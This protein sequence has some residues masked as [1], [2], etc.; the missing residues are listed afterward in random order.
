MLHPTW[1]SACWVLYVVVQ[2]KQ[3]QQ[4]KPASAWWTNAIQLL[5]VLLLETAESNIKALNVETIQPIVDSQL[6]DLRHVQPV[7]LGAVKPKFQN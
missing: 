6:N 7:S 4:G 3:Q 1:Q 5:K 2:Q